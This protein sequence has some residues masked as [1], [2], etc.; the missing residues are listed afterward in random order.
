MDSAI[1][2]AKLANG[3]TAQVFKERTGHLL[4]ALLGASVLQQHPYNTTVYPMCVFS[5]VSS[6]TDR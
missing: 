6:V 3:R 1:A 4:R 5:F 2:F